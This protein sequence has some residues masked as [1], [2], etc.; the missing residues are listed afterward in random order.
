[1]FGYTPYVPALPVKQNTPRKI[2]S[3]SLCFWWE[4]IKIMLIKIFIIYYTLTVSNS[5]QRH[6]RYRHARESPDCIPETPDE[7]CGL[8]Q[9]AP[10]PRLR[11]TWKN[12]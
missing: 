9:R 11:H 1:M 5:S 7:H 3:H 2:P 10:S 4:P 6:L 8:G 12:I